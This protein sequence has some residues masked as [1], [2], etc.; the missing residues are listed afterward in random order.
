MTVLTTRIR[1]IGLM[2]FLTCALH[3]Q[4]QPLRPPAVPLV[5]CD[6]Y[7]SIWSPA[8]RLTDTP[9]NHWTRVPHRLTSLVRI[10]GKTYRIMG[11]EPRDM[12]ALEQRRL[13]VMP[14]TT[15]FLFEGEG[16]RL[17]LSFMT[18]LLPDDLLV[19]SR[20]VTYL[21]WQV[22]STDGKQ[23]EVA[24]Y[25]DNTA[26]L[27]VNTPS[28]EVTWAIEKIGDLDAM[29][30]GTVEQPVL[31]R[32][33]DGVR[34]DW[35]YEYVAVSK[36]Q[37][38]KIL[39]A[40]PDT[41][42][43]VL[44]REVGAVAAV[45]APKP[46]KEAPVLSVTFKLGKVGKEPVSRWLI[47][48]YDDIYSAQ[49]FNHNLKAYW[50]KDGATITDLLKRSAAEYDDLQQ[51]CGQ[52]DLE[53]MA[54]L[55]QAGGEKYAKLCALAYRQSLAAS[56]VVADDNGQP[57]FLCKE[58]TSNGCMGTV[59]VFYPQSPLPLLIS[60]S[61][62]RAMLIP[63]LEYAS[64]SRWK[65]PNAPHDVG[66]WPKAN[67]QAYGG[68]NSDGG[69]P[70]EET[71][72]MLLMVA[73][74]AQVEGNADFATTYWPT[75][76]TWAEYLKSKGFDPENQLC[77]DDFAGKL[78]HN[79]NLSAKAICALG[80]FG[81]LTAMRGDQ[82]K[83]EEYT[84]LAKEFALR[85]V[86]EADD[87][88]HFR[89]AF[90]RPGTWS[91]KYNLVWDRILGLNLFPDDAIKKEMTFYRKNI[92]K[93][94]LPLDGRKQ[95]AGNR[96][97]ANE[98]MAFWSKT[99]WA[100]WTACLTNNREDFEAITNPIYSFFNEATVRVGLTDLYFTD[101]PD[102]A[103]MH[104]RPVIGG[105]FIKMLYDKDVWKKW[106]MR[107][108]TKANGPWAPLPSIGLGQVSVVD[109]LDT[110]AKNDFY[111]ANRQP[112]APGPFLKL[113]I[114]S[115]SPKGW[116]R[117]MLE[118]ER[119]GMT[120]RLK[121]ISPWLNI[122]TSA[123]ASKEG[124]GER[125]WEEMPYW[126]KGFGDL[127][128]V[129]RDDSVIAEARHWIEAVLSSQREDGWFGPRALLTSL[130]GK[131]DLWPHMVMLNVLQ[132]YYEFTLD[133]RAVTVMTRYMKWENAL[134]V[135]AF[136]EGY[137]PKIRAGDNIESAHWLYNRTGEPWLL[138]L[139]KKIHEGMARWDT[140]VINW[141][142]VNIAQGFRA[143][144]VFWVQSK[145]PQDLLSAELNYQKVT[146]MYGQF[147]GGTFVADEN[148]RPGYTDP[149]GGIETCGIVEFMHSFEML[150][151]ITGNPLW[152]DR[153]E[154]LAFNSLPA[155]QTADLKGLH[156]LTC[157]NQVQLDRGN[158][159]PAVQ[160]SGT[161]FSYSPFEVYRCCQHNVS[162]GWPYF[163]EE[164]WL[165]TPDNGLCA[166]LYS[167]C[168]VSAKVGDGTQVKITEDTDYPFSD[169]IQCRLA[170]P[171]AVKFPLYLRVP[172][173]CE[174]AT[175]TIN[176]KEVESKAGPLSFI[177]VA[178]RWADGD[179]VTLHLPMRVAVRKWAKNKDA[180]S[181]DYGPLSF[182]LAIK[183][184]WATYGNRSPNWPEREVF[185]ESAWNYGLVLDPPDPARSFE[186]VRKPDPVPGQPFTPETAPLQL[187]AKA[188][189]IS[190]WQQDRLGMVGLLQQSPAKSEEPVE[191]VTL[192]PMGA[193]RLR[194]SMFPIIG[195]GPDAH[196]WIAP[197]KPRASPP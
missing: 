12:P 168:E 138:D 149:R 65:W 31:R 173:W 142:N 44:E 9:T 136:G 84:K 57:L 170:A 95:R 96:G 188:H 30:V 90:D 1:K 53:M 56:K 129:L 62:S 37:G 72:N 15:M 140:D 67:G 176:G 171:K 122:E 18:P 146:G 116:L 49:F 113:P 185:P 2:F 97:E 124:K 114:G 143:G 153:C 13:R 5:A 128:Y 50:K 25:Y 8:D 38:A 137:W 195:S 132:S 101:Q 112:L 69:M 71:G 40:P 167:A 20:P 32:K 150:A 111:I 19:F 22:N 88:D 79:V 4:G 117:H 52:F 78:A 194:I 39:I 45:E 154:E 3:G 155:A 75:L 42:R 80:A 68:A 169:T 16:V 157:A 23:H 82:A 160:N 181:V 35:G 159:S 46:A 183:E 189:K 172:R 48:A 7:F 108:R 120:G 187:K 127:G 107:D 110:G 152:A 103:R 24:V 41:A 99:D 61:L 54:D 76:T 102:A 191:Q 100:F 106:A 81:K 144:T 186:V 83:A 55:T 156:Y 175:V 98:R 123:W 36:S 27:V 193:S 29:K 192:I 28:Q 196:E 104:S 74:V 87:G 43:Q 165:A 190:G 121:E 151:K 130:N 47:L 64:S 34:I 126:L 147:P 174:N 166:S 179:T 93:Y 109:R 60:P 11:D 148:A 197:S 125:G 70:V 118:L 14:T 178:R 17:S 163:A 180:V 10:D 141:H 91:S 182:S 21:T 184:R 33:G 161:M 131:P 105:L 119:E 134:P 94:G 115:I 73:A 162:H 77:T 133:P 135:S 164:L 177:V 26:E 6:P 51:R 89:L 58:N 86:K 66:T 92:D 145:D 63:V 85:W 139:A 158:K 59:D